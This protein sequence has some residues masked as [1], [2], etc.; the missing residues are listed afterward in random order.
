MARKHGVWFGFA[1]FAT[2][3]GLALLVLDGAL[4]GVVS[5][6]AVLVFVAV[7]ANALREADPAASD[8]AHRTG[9]GGWFGGWF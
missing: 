1:L 7:C 5:L 3:I 4:A 8:R 9:I 6:A 2:L